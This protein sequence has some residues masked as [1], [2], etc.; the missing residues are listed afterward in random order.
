MDIH[1]NARLTPLGRERLVKMVLDGQ[2]PQAVSE[3]VGVCPRTVQVGR[4]LQ[5][6]KPGRPAGLPCPS[7]H[8][9]HGQ[10]GVSR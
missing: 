3:A 8:E 4:A 7:F 1:K 5:R 9:R 2:T 10:R 6:R